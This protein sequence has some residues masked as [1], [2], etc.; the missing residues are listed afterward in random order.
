MTQRDRALR[1]PNLF[2]RNFRGIPALEV[3][4]LG[5][6]TLLTG[7]NGVGKTTVL[8][9]LETY[10]GAASYPVLRRILHDRE[11]AVSEKEAERGFRSPV[12]WFSLFHGHRRWRVENLELPEGD[13]KAADEL[14]L[15]VGPK[16]EAEW[17]TLGL[18]ISSE[19]ALDRWGS[20][21][22]ATEGPMPPLSL[23]VKFRRQEWETPIFHVSAGR[24]RPLGRASRPAP[25]VVCR[26]I[27]PTLVEPNE[28]A[29]YWGRVALTPE[30]D[31]VMEVLGD[32]VAD[33]PE[34]I[35]LL[36]GEDGDGPRFV[37]RLALQEARVPLKSL[38]D[39]ANRFFG[40][41]L[42]L[43]TA[44]GGMLFIDE[45]ENGI[46]HQVQESYWSLIFDFAREH[47]VQV[48]ATTHSWDAVTGFAR[49]AQGFGDD[50]ALIRLEREDGAIRAVEYTPDEIQVVADQ[51]IE[52][53]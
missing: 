50:A 15:V 7:R 45:A 17:L 10:A 29:E 53:R 35:A 31:L 2:V 18:G 5:R 8:E 13:D 21:A 16:A 3:S 4:R 9:A 49:A 48:I 51:G 36:G 43:A 32:V 27:G 19:E 25:W 11:E 34:R 52:V 47:N 20:E 41:V 30:E 14:T 6:V 42:A 40:L 46:H 26:R 23:Y 33:R 12:N 38:G 1:V 24:V 39:G 28:L 44:K 37:A 22:D